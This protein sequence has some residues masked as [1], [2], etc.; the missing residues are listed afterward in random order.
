MYEFNT[1]EILESLFL[2]I[3][4]HNYKKIDISQLVLEED[5]F[6]IMKEFTLQLSKKLNREQSRLYRLATENPFS[7]KIIPEKIRSKIM[8]MRVKG[9]K[10]SLYGKISIEETRRKFLTSLGLNININNN[11]IISHDIDS[12][13]GLKKALRFKKIE[14]KYNIESTW[15]IPTGGFNIDKKIVRILAENG[16]VASH[17]TRHDGKL[18]N[19]RRDLIAEEL[20]KSKAKLEEIVEKEIHGFRTPLLQYNKK[21]VGA[22][23][24]VGFAYDSSMPTWEPVHPSTMKADGIE[25]INPF[26]INGICEIPVTLPQD[27]QMLHVLRLTTKQTV[28]Q[29]LNLMGEISELGGIN[30]LLIHPDYEFANEDNLEYYDNLLQSINGVQRITSIKSLM[31]QL[32]GCPS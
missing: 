21:I 19:L 28:E 18:L 3:R 17:G 24:D 15:F 4:I 1:K 8:R 29:W 5:T 20:S 32:L 10:V 31:Q 26:I 13:K 23:S 7:Y 16:E 11:T 2:P 14:D 12:E 22:I 6:N 9:T 25:L 30:M 27:H